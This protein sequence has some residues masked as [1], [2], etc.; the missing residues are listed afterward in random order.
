[1]LLCDCI[2]EHF[3]CRHSHTYTNKHEFLRRRKQGT[4]EAD[5]QFRALGAI[6]EAPGLIFS[7]CTGV[8]DHQ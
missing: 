3:I 7:N 4:G 5:Q 1:M 6:A 2:L 8:H